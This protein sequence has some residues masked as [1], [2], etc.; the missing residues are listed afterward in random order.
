MDK[1]RLDT[2][3]KL[4]YLLPG[5]EWAKNNPSGLFERRTTKTA[6]PHNSEIECHHCTLCFV[7]CPNQL[8]ISSVR[9]P[10]ILCRPYTPFTRV[11]RRGS[12]QFCLYFFRRKTAVVLRKVAESSCFGC[13]QYD[14]LYEL[15]NRREPW[16]EPRK[17][18][19]GI[20]AAN[21]AL[22]L[23]RAISNTS[24]TGC[25]VTC[26]T[27][28]HHYCRLQRLQI[29]SLTMC[30]QCAMR[31]TDADNSFV[32]KQIAAAYMMRGSQLRNS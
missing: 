31:L 7:Y 25:D 17:W 21:T 5:N 28:L 8:T 2:K 16:L 10:I 23:W 1:K 20:G 27:W 11:S 12:L 29:A 19:S 18:E 15:Q 13:G 14:S 26:A 3:N 9:S 22:H 32:R 24:L 30:V 6:K 4:K